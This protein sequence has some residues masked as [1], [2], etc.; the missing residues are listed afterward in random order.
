[1]PRLSGIFALFSLLSRPVVRE[2][3]DVVHQT[4][5]LPLPVHLRLT[6]QR[7][8]LTATTRATRK[9]RRA[10]FSVSSMPA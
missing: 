7:E 9:T 1:V 4:E 10:I 6:A 2:L 8:A 5:Q 3:L